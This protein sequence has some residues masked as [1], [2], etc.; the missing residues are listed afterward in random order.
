MILTGIRRGIVSP[1][2]STP[3][4][5]ATKSF[6][7]RLGRSALLSRAHRDAGVDVLAL[8]EPGS[9]E[10]EFHAVAGELPH[11]GEPAA[12]VVAVALAALGHQPSVISGAFNW[13]R[14][15]AAFRLLP[16]SWLAL[17]ARRVME[18]QTPPESR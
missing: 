3:L 11:A 18:A 5:S 13:L 6:D 14:A 15:N 16:R 8:L 1:C 17:I 4:Y 9:T 2:R 7:N 12:D 10:S